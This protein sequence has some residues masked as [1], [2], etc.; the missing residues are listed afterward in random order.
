MHGERDAAYGA[1]TQNLANTAEMWTAQLRHKLRAGAVVEPHEVAALLISL[2][3]ARLVA[4]P[5]KRDN[6]LDVAGYAACGWEVAAS[7]LWGG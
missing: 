6:W 2:K 4:S 1:P 7:S 5:G 3:L